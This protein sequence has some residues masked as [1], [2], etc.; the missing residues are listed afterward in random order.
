MRVPNWVSNPLLL[1]SSLGSGTTFAS[2]REAK[3]RVTEVE[4]AL[5]ALLS[6]VMSLTLS[7]LTFIY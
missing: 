7:S 1:S 5:P 4:I 3:M 6:T 2:S